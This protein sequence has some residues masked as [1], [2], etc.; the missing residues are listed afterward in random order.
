MSATIIE[1]RDI[2]K[3]YGMG[4]I[5]V[6]ALAGVS[7]KIQPGEFVA[8]MGPSGSGKSTLMN[9]L[10]CLDKPTTGQYLLD[11]EDVSRL[12]KVQLATVR[13]R[14]LGYIFQSF[15][16]LART[17]A[18]NNV[19]L[20]LM[21]DRTTMRTQNERLERAQIVLEDVGLGDRM[22]HMPHELSGGQQQ[23]VA[24]ARALINNPV[25]ILADEPTG[26]LDSQSGEEIMD[27][28]HKLHTQ[29]RTIMMVTHDPEIAAHTQ[30]TIRFRDGRIEKDSRNG[31]PRKNME[32]AA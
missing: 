31:K 19:L 11:D 3:I 9:I 8:V 16:L 14:K 10:G 4:D 7:I 18:I 17:P 5:Q 2:S 13:N 12:D 32:D 6:A 30:R 26:N 24:I 25:L 21:Y 23:R 22:Q 29:G 15:N 20:P 27:I 28:L 1:T